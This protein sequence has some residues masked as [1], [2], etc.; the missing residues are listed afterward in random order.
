MLHG[1]LARLFSIVLLWGWCSLA[2]AEPPLKYKFQEG[3]KL[4][5]T[6]NQ[7][8]VTSSSVA[9][10]KVDLKITQQIESLW[11]VKKIAADGA[12]E[13]GQTTTR[14]VFNMEMPMNKVEYDSKTGKLPENDSLKIAELLASMVDQEIT[15]T[16]SPTGEVSNVRIPAKITESLAA[17]PALKAMGGTFSAEGIK[18]LIASSIV[19]FPKPEMKKGDKWDSAPLAMEAGGMK[20]ITTMATTFEGVETKDGKDLAKFTRKTKT[21]ITPPPGLEAAVKSDDNDATIW[22]DVAAGLLFESNSK[23]TLVI[24]SK[25]FG[26]AFET[27][28]S[29]TNL[30]KFTPEI[31]K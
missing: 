21:G 3:Q 11:I 22:F 25:L 2:L 7:E 9:G 16:M 1:S 10:Q 8:T 19:S 23:Q 14:V 4:P 5:Y 20:I 27:T 26:Q 24:E 15:L 17:N 18:A 29:Q 13:I 31:K 12:A 28:Q 6:L 30:M